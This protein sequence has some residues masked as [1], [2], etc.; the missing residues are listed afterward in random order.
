MEYDQTAEPW[1]PTVPD[2]PYRYDLPPYEKTQNTKHG[3]GSARAAN[4]G[5]V[6]RKLKAERGIGKHRHY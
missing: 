5:R 6:K 4:K 1:E 2:E 3:N